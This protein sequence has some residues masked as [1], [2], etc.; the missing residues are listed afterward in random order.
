MLCDLLKVGTHCSTHYFWE[1]FICVLVK[2]RFGK[3]YCTQLLIFAKSTPDSVSFLTNINY[4]YLRLR[5]RL[6]FIKALE[7][8]CFKKV[9]N[10]TLSILFCQI[11]GKEIAN[12][13]LFMSCTPKS[14]FPFFLALYSVFLKVAIALGWILSL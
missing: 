13:I 6:T 7:C 8:G 14:W 2:H 9:N 4:I 12:F 1:E 5:L 3:L 11:F 10:K